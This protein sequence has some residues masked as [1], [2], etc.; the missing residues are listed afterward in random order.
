MAKVSHLLVVHL[1]PAL[2]WQGLAARAKLV[3]LATALTRALRD[4]GVGIPAP[5]Y[6]AAL[7]DVR[8]RRKITD[9]SVPEFQAARVE[10]EFQADRAVSAE[11]LSGVL[12]EALSYHNPFE[13]FRLTEFGEPEELD[14]LC[15][16]TVQA[17]TRTSIA[18]AGTRRN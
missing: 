9:R 10:L 7:R 11:D 14:S 12:L 1:V 8:W 16:A 3:L 18:V 13:E 15:L 6:E 5:F 17:T 4:S 2:P